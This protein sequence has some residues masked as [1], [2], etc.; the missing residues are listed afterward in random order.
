MRIGWPESQPSI[1]L[2]FLERRRRARPPVAPHTRRDRRREANLTTVVARLH[3]QSG[4]D[5]TYA[6]SYG[7]GRQFA[8]HYRLFFSSPAYLQ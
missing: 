2:R 8:Q 4:A 6:S 5:P 1:P 7:I 3:C